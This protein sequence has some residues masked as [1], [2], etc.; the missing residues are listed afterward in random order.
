MLYCM[1]CS[2][3]CSYSIPIVLSIRD[4]LHVLQSSHDHCS[5]PS[6]VSDNDLII[7][8]IIPAVLKV[9][10]LNQFYVQYVYL[11][12]KMSRDKFYTRAETNSSKLQLVS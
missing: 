3:Y 5:L 10:L 9:C 8:D 7:E 1:N 12:D 2:V 4:K 6:S 11:L